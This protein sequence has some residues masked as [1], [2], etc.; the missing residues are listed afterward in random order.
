MRHPLVGSID[1]T[2]AGP[3]WACERVTP[4]LPRWS[5]RALAQPRSTI[6]L[7]VGVGDPASPGEAVFRHPPVEITRDV[8]GCLVAT[9]AGVSATLH[10]REIELRFDPDAP[11]RY[12][13]G[14]LDIVWPFVLPRHGLYHVHGAAV[15]DPGGIGWLLAGD[16]NIG[17]S[18]STLAL[19]SA[20]WQ[21][22]A[23]DAVYLTQQSAGCVVAHGWAEPIRL[24][25]RSATALG[26]A[27]EEA[28]TGAKSAALLTEQLDARRRD[29]FPID[30]VVFP[31]FGP[32]TALRPLRSSEALAHLVRAS[33]WIVGQPTVAVEYLALLTRVASLPAFTLVLGPELL[34]H[35]ERLAE[36][37][38]HATRAAA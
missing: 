16:A 34:D 29:S 33:A 7:R 15:R 8:H 38:Q 19:V 23:D 24:T 37:L 6:S 17:K 27:R 35:P 36:H 3:A 4:W 25:A 2:L 32:S 11:P 18:T 26:V 31:E 1:V 22:A 28:T 5:V 20:G 10:E 14:V 30:R 21:Y 9:A 12:V 13:G